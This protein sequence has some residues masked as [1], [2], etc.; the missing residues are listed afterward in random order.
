MK[1]APTLATT[2]AGLNGAPLAPRI[3]IT[4]SSGT[5]KSTLAE[6]LAA[7]WNVPCIPEGMRRRIR[8]GLNQHEMSDAERRGLAHEL[9]A[10]MVGGMR[11]ALESDGGFV[12]DRS[13]IDSFAFWLY[14]GFGLEEA[15]TDALADTMRAD[16]EMLD[17]VVVLPWGTIPLIADGVRTPNK[18]IQLHFQHLVEGLTARFMPADRIWRMPE[19][20]VPVE[21]RMRWIMDRLARTKE[22][23]P[24]TGERAG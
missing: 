5:G 11:A 16:I 8:S 21:D 24:R 18:W 6:A 7:E 23:S 19:N 4:G 17:A 12:S 2:T 22:P 20:V 14:Y 10:E 13:P 1:L 9:Y 3:A 15:E